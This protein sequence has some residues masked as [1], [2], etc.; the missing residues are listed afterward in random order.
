M[1]TVTEFQQLFRFFPEH[2]FKFGIERE[3][4]LADREGNIVPRAKSVYEALYAEWGDLFTYE[5][6]ACQIESRTEIVTAESLLSH[7]A[8]CEGKLDSVLCTL[9]LQK[10]YMEVAPENMLLE[11]YPDPS[12][13]YAALKAAMPK[14]V[15]LA[16]CR[17]AGTHIHIG[18]P[19]SATAL[20]VYNRVITHCDSLC[21]LGDSSSG[22]RLAIYKKV[23]PT[24][25]PLPYE[26]WE[27]FYQVA[28]KEGFAENPR[29]CW[30][31][32][33]LTKHGTIEFRMFGVTKSL[34]LIVT[35]A[36]TCRE[37]CVNAAYG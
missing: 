18:M 11:V 26:S 28:R 36:N 25:H 3:F 10:L 6:S 37:L 34:S 23:A 21:Q 22:L 4:F 1:N 7:L 35:W 9:E 31:L 30:T 2:A 15:L 14:D 32:I 27:H 24:C 8:D 13:R 19:D 16:A 33:R 12:G 5:L 29:N 17:V 20:R